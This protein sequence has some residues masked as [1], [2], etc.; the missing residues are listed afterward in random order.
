VGVGIRFSTFDVDGPEQPVLDLDRDGQLGHGR[1]TGVHVAGVTS[2]VRHV[3]RL[4]RTGC[5]SRDA[6]FPVQ[7]DAQTRRQ[8]EF[9]P[10]GD[11][12]QLPPGLVH[13]Q[14]FAVLKVE[15]SPAISR[16]VSTIACSSRSRTN[17]CPSR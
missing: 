16:T 4:P 13:Q 15:H 10:L 8:V 7:R 6:P 9:T 2:H 14:E 17:A 12:D 11:D 1:K 5:G 3:H